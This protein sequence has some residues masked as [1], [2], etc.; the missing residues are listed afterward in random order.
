MPYKVHKLT[1]DRRNNTCGFFLPNG[2]FYH[3]VEMTFENHKQLEDL[4]KR[5][6]YTVDYVDGPIGFFDNE[7]FEVDQSS[8]VVHQISKI[9]ESYEKKTKKYGGRQTPKKAKH[10]V[11][12]RDLIEQQARSLGIRTGQWSTQTLK[13]MIETTKLQ[14]QRTLAQNLS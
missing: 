8:V 14:P 12:E 2:G 11:I 10:V 5:P 13:Q 9:V 4:S 7:G 6:G 3:V 1:D